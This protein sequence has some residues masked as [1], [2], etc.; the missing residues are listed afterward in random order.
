MMFNTLATCNMY[1]TTHVQ[2]Y[3]Y[4]SMYNL[5]RVVRKQYS[6]AHVPSL[7][8]SS[9]HVQSSHVDGTTMRVF[10]TQMCALVGDT[11]VAHKQLL[12]AC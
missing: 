3:M 9:A 8:H 7:M 12:S 6:S 4:M 10:G 5:L 11:H 2:V 1:S